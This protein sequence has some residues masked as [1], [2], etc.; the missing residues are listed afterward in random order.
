[1]KTCPKCMRELK[2][3]FNSD[4]G[5]ELALESLDN[6]IILGNCYVDEHTYYCEYCDEFFKI[7]IPF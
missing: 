7:W 4:S 2:K 6:E 5:D 3:V 1:M